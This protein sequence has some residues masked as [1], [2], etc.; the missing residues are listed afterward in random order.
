MKLVG[1]GLSVYIQ[2]SLHVL[3]VLYGVGEVLLSGGGVEF[4][5]QS[6]RS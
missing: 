6:V 1:K 3:V 5:A 4:G 2:P